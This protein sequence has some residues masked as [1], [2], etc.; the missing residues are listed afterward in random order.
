MLIYLSSNSNSIF[1]SLITSLS[2]STLLLNKNERSHF[3]VTLLIFNG[4]DGTG[5]WSS[6]FFIHPENVINSDIMII[7]I[8]SGSSFFMVQPLMMIIFYNNKTCEF[9][10]EQ[11]PGLSEDFVPYVFWQHQMPPHMTHPMPSRLP[12]LPGCPIKYWLYLSG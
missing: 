3:V 9:N 7:I 5:I 1:T 2:A 12:H 10:T 4:S 6:A 11:N 8:T